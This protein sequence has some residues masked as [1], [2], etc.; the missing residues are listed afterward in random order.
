M[1]CLRQAVRN[2]LAKRVCL[3][4]RVPGRSCAKFKLLL[5]QRNY[6]FQSELYRDL[7]ED[8][9]KSW[10]RGCKKYCVYLL[11]GLIFL[12]QQP[13]DSKS[14]NRDLMWGFAWQLFQALKTKP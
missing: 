13:R 5:F 12:S 11:N 14:F 10:L 6:H 8:A 4:W 2:F 1:K 7:T 9:W 3:L